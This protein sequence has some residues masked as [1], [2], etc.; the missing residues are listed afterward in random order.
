MQLIDTTGYSRYG[1]T[2]ITNDIV[3]GRYAS[4]C[5]C[6]GYPC[7]EYRLKIFAGMEMCPG[8]VKQVSAPPIS[9]HPSITPSGD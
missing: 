4:L 6:C 3:S 5:Y 2:L 8:C 9:N 1:N 7:P